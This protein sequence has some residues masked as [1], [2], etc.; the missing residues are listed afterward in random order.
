MRSLKT[1][2]LSRETHRLQVLGQVTGDGGGVRQRM[3]AKGRFD[4]C[5]L[6]SAFQERP[7][8][9]GFSFSP[10]LPTPNRAETLF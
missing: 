9:S 6:L 7:L 5:F 8:S 1:P 3:G 2:P 4:P 10:R